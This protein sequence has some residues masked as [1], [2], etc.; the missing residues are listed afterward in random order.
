MRDKCYP[1]EVA[2]REA[3]AD[4][5]PRDTG[6]IDYTVETIGNAEADAFIRRY[7][8]LGNI[9]NNPIARATIP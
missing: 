2:E 3:A 6:P 9:G 1:R 7:E 4:P 5:R 8:W